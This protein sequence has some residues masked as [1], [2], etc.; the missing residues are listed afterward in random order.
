MLISSGSP[1]E[2]MDGRKA[3]DCDAVR[4]WFGSRVSCSVLDAIRTGYP[5]CLQLLPR[6]ERA[7]CSGLCSMQAG[8]DDWGRLGRVQSAECSVQPV[9]HHRLQSVCSPRL[10]LHVPWFDLAAR[11]LRVWGIGMQSSWRKLPS[12]VFKASIHSCCAC[13]IDVLSRSMSRTWHQLDW[14]WMNRARLDPID[15]LVQPLNRSLKSSSPSWGFQASGQRQDMDM[16][17]SKTPHPT[18]EV[19]PARCSS[20]TLITPGLCKRVRTEVRTHITFSISWLPSLAPNSRYSAV[21][22]LFLVLSG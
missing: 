17:G 7:S 14:L 12:L 18:S 19:R 3:V 8:W 1:A 4:Q 6:S 2:A 5:P 21:E 20:A 13:R 16:T 15:A 9:M 22:C 11:S 10:V